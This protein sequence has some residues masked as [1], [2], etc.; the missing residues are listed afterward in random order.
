MNPS[1]WCAAWL[2]TATTPAM[3]GDDRLVPPIRYWA[4]YV[5]FG[6]TWVSPTSKPVFGSPGI[7]M[8]GTARIGVLP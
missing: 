6:N 8:S 2:A 7:E 3:S 1:L 5:P 4:Q